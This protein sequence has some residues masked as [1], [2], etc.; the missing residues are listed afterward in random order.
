MWKSVVFSLKDVCTLQIFFTKLLQNFLHFNQT[1]K[2][3]VFAY[4]Y[5]DNLYNIYKEV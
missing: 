1:W 2:Y 5:N 3:T 4:F